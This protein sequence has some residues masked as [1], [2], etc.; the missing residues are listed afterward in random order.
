M[1]QGYKGD[2]NPHARTGADLLDIAGKVRYIGITSEQDGVTEL[3]AIRNARQVTALVAM[4][5]QAPVNQQ[6]VSQGSTRY[7]IALHLLDGTA[8][9]PSSRLTLRAVVSESYRA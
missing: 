9:I 5:L 8:V 4:I 7:F 2:T 6:Y 3:G 1:L